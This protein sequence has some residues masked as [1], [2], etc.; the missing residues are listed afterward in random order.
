MSAG[1]NEREHR[2][3]NPL[4]NIPIPCSCAKS[5]NT[6]KSFLLAFPVLGLKSNTIVYIYT[7]F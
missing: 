7:C 4:E 5:S 1:G 2:K 3:V 6:S